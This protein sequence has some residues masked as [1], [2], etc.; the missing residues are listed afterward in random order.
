MTS[1]AIISIILAALG[2]MIAI[3][4]AFKQGA[5]RKTNLFVTCGEPFKRDNPI[6]WEKKYILNSKKPIWAICYGVPDISVES[7]L[8]VLPFVIRNY[9]KHSVSDIQITLSSREEFNPSRYSVFDF[10]KMDENVFGMKGQATTFRGEYHYA[11][12]VPI[13]NP[14]DPLT[15]YLP[16]AVDKVLFKSLFESHVLV[17]CDEE[18]FIVE[19]IN[20]NFSAK[21]LKPREFETNLLIALCRDMKELPKKTKGPLANLHELDCPNLFKGKTGIVFKPMPWSFWY[22]LMFPKC[23]RKKPYLLAESKYGILQ[24]DPNVL[25]E[26]FENTSYAPGLLVFDQ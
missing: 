7:Y 4:I 14:R 24:S 25:V 13:L 9:S 26:Q 19:K 5:F 17:N 16:I 2:I 8:L 18:E 11:I 22:F 10:D 3:Y 12:T 6:R 23:R 20:C 1:E 21:H 15:I